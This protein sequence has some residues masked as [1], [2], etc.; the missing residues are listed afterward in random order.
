MQSP[1]FILQLKRRAPRGFTLIELTAACALVAILVILALPSYQA[2]VRKSKRASAESHL[3]DIA[4]RQQQYLFNSRGY[5]PDLAALSMTTPNDV[6]AAYTI[7]IAAT[8][9]APPTFTVTAT[10]KTSQAPDLG[11]AALTIDNA[12]A[13]APGGAW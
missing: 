6:A 12:G 2:Q 5:A 13:K 8:N 9:G 3:M 4:A 10:P 1:S 7:T 11:G